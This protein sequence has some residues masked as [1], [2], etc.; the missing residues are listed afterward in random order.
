MVN[1]KVGFENGKILLEYLDDNN[2][3]VK[4]PDLESYVSKNK[5]ISDIGEVINGDLDDYLKICLDEYLASLISDKKLKIPKNYIEFYETQKPKWIHN[6]IEALNYQENI[7]YVVQEGEIKPV[8]YYSTGIV[9][10]STNWSDGLHQ[11][12]QIKHNLKMTSE[13]FTTNFLS[14]IGFIN[15]YK[16]IYGLTG[17][18]GSEKAK[19]VL[20]DVYNV[21]LVNV[22]QLRQKQYLELE[23]IVTQDE[24]QWVEQICSTVL[25]ETKKDRGVLIICENIAHANRLGDLLKT[26][27]RS[28][29]VKL[30][31]M[32][33]MN[34]EKH[35]E[36]ILPGE[37]II[38]TNLAG[39]GTDIRTTKV[40]TP[41]PASLSLE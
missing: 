6:A 25:I 30:Y 10:S 11:F 16:N 26:Q 12:L 37:I 28:T 2:N 36:K 3:I 39:R 17:T 15:N 22:P 8:D 1:G 23:T 34:Q 7:H 14:N 31:T 24:T 40:L 27:H 19:R 13:T 29:A 33:N 20:K 35:V 32:N 38:A 4:I 41:F 21:D 9:Q 5:D 18:L